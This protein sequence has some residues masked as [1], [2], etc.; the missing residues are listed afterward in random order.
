M[1]KKHNKDINKDNKT[2]AKE[3]AFADKHTPKEVNVDSVKEEFEK[4]E[5]QEEVKKIEKAE[6]KNLH[7]S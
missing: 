4:K 5:E 7:I 2:N 6:N 1:G 3:Q